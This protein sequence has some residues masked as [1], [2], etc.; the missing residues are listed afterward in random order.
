[1]K[2]FFFSAMVVFS[3]AASAAALDIGF[4]G[5]APGASLRDL[6]GAVQVGLPAG[7]AFPAGGAAL[8][9]LSGETMAPGVYTLP[10]RPPS[11]RAPLS[12]EEREAEFLFILGKMETV[13][14]HMESKQKFYDF[15]YEALKS[16]YLA[17]VRAAASDADYRAAV[18]EFSAAFHDPHLAAHFYDKTPPR[19]PLVFPIVK[20][21][22]TEDGILITRIERLYGDYEEIEAGLEESLRL[23]KGAKAL[24]VDMRGNPGGDDSHTTKYLARLISRPARGGTVSIKISSETLARYG[25]LEEDPERPGWTPWYSGQVKPKGDSPFG[26]PVAMLI[27]G[28]CVSSCEGT[29]MRFKFS[30]IAKLY[31][32]TTRGSSGYPVSIPLPFSRGAVYIPTWIQLQ[33]DGKPIEDHGITPHVRIEPEKALEAALAD[34]REALKN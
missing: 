18:Q 26:G 8:S 31:G 29:A 34:L 10:F 23:A 32:A 6:A 27:D 2:N 24:V 7:I 33:P 25:E 21:T 12:A 5:K 19:Q 16:D 22:L 3:S 9:L 11:R 4:D 1:M 17:R 20:N 28:R 13:Y 14:S 30:G 15:S